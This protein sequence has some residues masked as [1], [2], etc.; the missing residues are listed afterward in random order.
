MTARTY[1]NLFADLARAGVRLRAINSCPYDFGGCAAK[2][3]GPGSSPLP[4][5]WARFHAI[6]E[7]YHPGIENHMIGWW[8]TPEEHRLLAI[9]PTARR[10]LDQEHVAAHSL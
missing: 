8:W 3:A 4:S 2:S 10:R 1:E 5:S 6:A 9:G 7:R